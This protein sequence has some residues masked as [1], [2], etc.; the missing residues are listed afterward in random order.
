MILDKFELMSF[1]IYNKAF[2][3]LNYSHNIKGLSTT[4]K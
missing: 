4:Q 1:V 3:P 2:P